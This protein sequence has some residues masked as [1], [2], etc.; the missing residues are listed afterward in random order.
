MAASP[1]KVYSTFDILA[2]IEGAA[3]QLRGPLLELIAFHATSILEAGTTELGVSAT[4]TRDGRKAD[5]DVLCHVETKTALAV[6]YKGRA[7]HLADDEAVVND[8]LTRPIPV[9]DAFLREKH[10]VRTLGAPRHR[11]QA[12]LFRAHISKPSNSVKRSSKKSGIE[13]A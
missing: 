7:K 5:I 3:G 11:V 2:K 9:F 1:D 13:T 6:E 12:L 10:M 4:S 8:W